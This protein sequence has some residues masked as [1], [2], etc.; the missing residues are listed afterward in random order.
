MKNVELHL[1]KT[2]EKLP[3]FVPSPLTSN[4]RP[5]VDISSELGSKEASYYQSLIGTLQWIVELG[6][7][8]ITCEVSMMAFMMAMP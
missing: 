2:N 7:V 8:D 4:Y 1:K 5:E 6:R 3:S